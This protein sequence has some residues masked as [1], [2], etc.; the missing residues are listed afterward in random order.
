MFL[1][2][3]SRPS[4]RD[5]RDSSQSKKDSEPCFI[6]GHI[7]TVN[8]SICD[9]HGPPQ[10]LGRFSVDGFGLFR[11][12]KSVGRPQ[13]ARQPLILVPRRAFSETAQCG[14]EALQA[15]STLRRDRSPELFAVRIPLGPKVSHLLSHVELSNRAR[16]HLGLENPQCGLGNHLLGALPQYRSRSQRRTVRRSYSQGILQA[17][18]C[19]RTL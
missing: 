11:V 1:G 12:S 2:W 17:G 9:S 4:A 19:R 18:K 3:L 15:S 10:V 7:L 13:L 14:A 5:P 8:R 6:C 16:P